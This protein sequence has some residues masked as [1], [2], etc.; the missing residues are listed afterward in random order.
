MPRTVSSIIFATVFAAALSLTVLP[1]CSFLPSQES[2]PSQD[3]VVSTNSPE[4][5]QRVLNDL[6]DQFLD[7]GFVG[8][9]RLDEYE[10]SDV[11]SVHYFRAELAVS[12]DWVQVHANMTAV[13]LESI[14]F[15]FDG[16]C[17]YKVD[18][19]NQAKKIV[20]VSWEAKTGG[21]SFV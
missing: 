8:I 15:D 6:S 19:F 12:S 14:I 21:S 13:Q 7:D 3:K 11:P 4:I 1:A 10:V 2:S 5:E 17:P 20:N 16:T 18:G 9:V